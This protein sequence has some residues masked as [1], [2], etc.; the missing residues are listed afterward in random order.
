MCKL[1]SLYIL[2]ILLLAK[3][4]S[5]VLSEPNVL[6]VLKEQ[7]V[8]KKRLVILT[9]KK[10]YGIMKTRLE[11]MFYIFYSLIAVLR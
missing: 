2:Y 10:I 9:K 5:A 7:L 4:R 3:R 1:T 11:K 8:I 6:K